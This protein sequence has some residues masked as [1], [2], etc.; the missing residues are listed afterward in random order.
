MCDPFRPRGRVLRLTNQRGA[1]PRVLEIRG[2]RRHGTR[3][4]CGFTTKRLYIDNILT[5]NRFLAITACECQVVAV[6]VSG[7][8]E[9]LYSCVRNV[10]HSCRF[11]RHSR[12]PVAEISSD[13][14]PAATGHPAGSV[15]PCSSGPGHCVPLAR[16]PPGSHTSVRPGDLG[17]PWLGA[18]REPQVL[19]LGRVAVLADDHGRW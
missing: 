18:G 15:A 1:A 16:A 19:D 17:L 9:T 2:S 10:F 4:G 11:H 12:S 13:S 3:Q 14:V 7:K 8:R 5:V 6:H